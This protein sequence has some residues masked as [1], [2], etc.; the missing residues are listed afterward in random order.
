[1]WRVLNEKGWRTAVLKLAYLTGLWAIVTF[2]FAAEIFLTTRGGPIKIS[3]AVA[4]TSAF[5]DWFPWILL[6]PIAVILAGKFRFENNAWRRS[7]I[8]HVVACLLFTLAYQALVLITFPRLYYVSGGAGVGVFSTGGQASPILPELPPADEAGGTVSVSAGPS[9]NTMFI[10]RR[11]IVPG[12]AGQVSGMVNSAPVTM[13]HFE[14]PRGPTPTNHFEFVFGTPT[15]ATAHFLRLAMLRTQFTVPI[16]WCIICICWVI[17]HFQ[18]ARE[19]ERRTLQLEARLTEANL[20]SLKMQLQPHFLFNTLNAISSLIHENPNAAD[21]MIGSLSQFLRTTLEMSAKNEIPLQIEL[22]FLELYL[23]IQQTRFGERLRI[24]SE[25]SSSALQALV[26]PLVLQPLVENSIRHGIES[27]ENG[28]TVIIRAWQKN[29]LLRLEIADDGEG[30]SGGQLLRPGNGIGLSN[31]EARLQALY[32]T[33]HHFTLAAN[34]PRGAIVTIEIPFRLS[35]PEN[36][37]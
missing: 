2:V 32:G 8:I 21:D 37:T 10:E 14:G 28:G 7:L 35:S 30:F 11:T 15:T 36:K 13:D 17:G 12:H 19:R 29:D 16:Y 22:R 18:E 31:T 20:Q 34:E 24:Q 27:C 25:I 1:M 3:W 9:P 26:P 33:K 4:A 23:E 5:R 6:S